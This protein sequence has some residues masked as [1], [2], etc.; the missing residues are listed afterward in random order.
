M[1]EGWKQ[2]LFRSTTVGDLRRCLQRIFARAGIPDPHISSDLI[3]AQ[4]TGVPRGGLPLEHASPVSGVDLDKIAT[5]AA[6]RLQREP[7]Q[8]ILEE[9]SFWDF[10]VAVRQGVLI[11]RPETEDLCR[12]VIK[13]LNKEFPSGRFSFADVGT[14][15]GILGITIA[16]EFPLSQG[17]C[18]DLHH[19]PALLARENG[20]KLG[21]SPTHLEVVQ[22][23]LLSCF[24]EQSL[25]VV[26]S[27]PPYIPSNQ[28]PQLMPEVSQ[29]EPVGA[30]DGGGDG[31][32]IIRRLL[33]QAGR[34]LRPNGLLVVEHGHGQ[35][36]SLAKMS[37]A[38]MN[39]HALLNDDAGR[40]RIAIWR[41]CREGSL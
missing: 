32:E 22:A 12:H 36:S 15:T 14:G 3:I 38:G 13:L 27:N 23:D 10:T 9:W 1:G 18:V 7:L 40:E 20:R 16:R 39:V 31:L 19:E 35:R 28:I 5:L 34:G 30:L 33:A 6:R 21:L 17:V 2:E 37:A 26:V 11:P 25:E 41:K 29:Y 24:R 4:V 8:Y